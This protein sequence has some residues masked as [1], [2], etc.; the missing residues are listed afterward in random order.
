MLSSHPKSGSLASTAALLTLLASPA[1]AV[2]AVESARIR[3]LEQKLEHSMKMIESLANKVQQLEQVKATPVAVAAVAAPQDARIDDLQKQVSDI[4]SA[5]SRA[6][7]VGLP[8]HGF[9]DVGAGRSTQDNAVYG[10]GTKGFAI[11]NFDLYLTPQFGDRVKAL[12]ELNF[13]IG[14]PDSLAAPQASGV[15]VDLERLQLGYTFAD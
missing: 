2:D 14:A 7:D 10:K 12:V 15:G 9:T 11:G 1:M 6:S 8:I 5:R 3:D 4:T 13:E